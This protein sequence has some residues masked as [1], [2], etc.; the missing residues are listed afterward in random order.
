MGEL[1]YTIWI[2]CEI[3]IAD[4]LLMAAMNF[5]ESIFHINLPHKDNFLKEMFKIDNLIHALL[6]SFMQVISAEKLSYSKA[7]MMF[8]EHWLGVLI[9]IIELGSLKFENL[10]NDENF[11]KLMDIMCRILNPYRESHNLFPIQKLNVN[12]IN[13]TIRVLLSFHSCDVNISPKID[14]IIATII[15]HLKTGTQFDLVL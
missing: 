1:F 15:F 10:E 9:I 11:S 3:F 13:E 7:E 8:I 5:L 6:E 12:V 4:D 2:I 14:Y